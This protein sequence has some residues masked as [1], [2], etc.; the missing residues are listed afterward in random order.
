MSQGRARWIAGW[1]VLT[2]SALLAQAVLRLTPIALEPWLAG[3]MS[4]FQIGLYIAWLIFN[5]W[6]EGYRG[7]QLRFCPRVVGRAFYLGEHPSVLRVVLALPFCMSLFHT[8]R[9]QLIVSWA[10]LGLL[11]V[12]VTLVKLLPQPWRGI[13]DGG[14]VLGL[15][16]GIV[17]LWVFFARAVWTGEIPV[18]D[19]LP[20]AEALNELSPE[21]AA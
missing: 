10:F 6:A 15:V 13:I 21:A 5:G 4:A 9:R 2:V 8:T 16:W 7:F 20:D 11:V 1:G 19:D 14:V 12:L 3:T 17:A 18:A